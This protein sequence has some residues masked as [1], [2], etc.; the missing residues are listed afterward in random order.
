MSVLKTVEDKSYVM[1]IACNDC[2][3]YFGK[4]KNI[5]LF[6]LV[7]LSSFLVVINGY[8]GHNEWI[9]Y[10]NMSL[11]AF[12]IFLMALQSKME[13]AE[14]ANMF[15]D[16]SKKYSQLYNEIVSKI[17]M[18]EHEDAVWIHEIVMKYEN[19]QNADISIPS[20]IRRRVIAK[21]HEKRFLPNCLLSSSDDTT[22]PNSVGA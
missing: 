7:F 15:S 6:P 21:F 17:A 11:N 13:I 14:K 1:S 4:I 12:N 16:L 8:D 18:N 19:L 3:R 22:P 9:Q 2:G 20:H 5:L 10:L